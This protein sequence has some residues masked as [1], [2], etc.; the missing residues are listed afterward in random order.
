M[1]KPV[2]RMRGTEMEKNRRGRGIGKTRERGIETKERKQNGGGR[3][4]ERERKRRGTVTWAVRIDLAVLRACRRLGSQRGPIGGLLLSLS[5]F[6]RFSR[7]PLLP[8][9]LFLSLIYIAARPPTRFF[10]QLPRFYLDTHRSARR[11]ART[12]ACTRARIYTHTHITA[13]NMYIPGCLITSADNAMRPFQYNEM[14]D[15]RGGHIADV[16]TG[17]SNDHA[18]RICIFMSLI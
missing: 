14:A 12:Y 6:L 18:S 17:R 10:T 3:G 1:E 11:Y 8:L 13:F 7:S 2:K 9:S 5:P 16:G 4:R 15:D